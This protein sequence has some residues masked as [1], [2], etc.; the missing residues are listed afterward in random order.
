MCPK[1]LVLG[2]PESSVPRAQGQRLLGWA[3]DTLGYQKKKKKKSEGSKRHK[4]KPVHRMQ[5]L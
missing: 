2:Y 3:G 5:Q 4:I 1:G